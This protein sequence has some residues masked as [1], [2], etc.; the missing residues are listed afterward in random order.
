METGRGQGSCNASLKTKP[1]SKPRSSILA[2][3]CKST[4]PT[5]EQGGKHALHGATPV[6]VVTEGNAGGPLQSGAP[7]VGM[8]RRT[9]P[10]AVGNDG[11]RP[12]QRVHDVILVSGVCLGPLEHVTRKLAE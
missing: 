3:F 10:L 6:L 2:M 7:S 9:A 11:V 8:W 4:A 5:Q 12:L 1:T